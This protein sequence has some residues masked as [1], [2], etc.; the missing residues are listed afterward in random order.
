MS[1]FPL[2]VIIALGAFAAAVHHLN[3]GFS[4]YF[5]FVALLMV[6]GGTLA[7]AVILIP[8]QLRKDL[9]DSIKSLIAS[10]NLTYRQVLSECMN[11]IKYRKVDSE[12]QAS[13]HIY[14][15][16][17][18]EGVELVNLGF[19]S[20]KVTQILFERVQAYGRRKRK[21]ANAI[22]N[23][24]KYPPAFGLMGTVLGLVNVMR[25]VSSGMDGKQTA[26][27]MA[28]ALVATM[29]G[30]VVANLF[31]NP[32]GE[33]VLKKTVEEESLGEIAVTA[34]SLLATT[35]SLLEA[36]EVLNSFAPVED[37]I[38]V[39]SDSFDEAAA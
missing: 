24:A 25:G 9:F 10:R 18:R 36:Q 11:T 2:G 39:F 21:V 19:S 23:L 29:Y 28:I 35:P 34:I 8:W 4:S 20:E 30:L 37:R 31:V 17:L 22:R 7:V 15:Q 6:L 3:Q 5:D 27:E 13:N 16:V 32:A 14:A 38:T 33:L 26:L 1:L 12:T